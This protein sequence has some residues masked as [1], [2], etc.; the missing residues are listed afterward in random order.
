MIQL[1][2]IILVVDHLIPAVFNLELILL[3]SIVPTFAQFHII[4]Q[5]V[6]A[7]L[8]IQRATATGRQT[9]RGPQ[10]VCVAISLW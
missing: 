3:L 7:A 10:D 2:S 1:N 8:P 6:S 9:P 4:H 5:S